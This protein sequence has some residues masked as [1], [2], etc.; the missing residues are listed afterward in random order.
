MDEKELNADERGEG[1]RIAWGEIRT[2]ESRPEGWRV[3]GHSHRD[4][5]FALFK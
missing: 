2:S 1:E 5:S 4:H 3:V